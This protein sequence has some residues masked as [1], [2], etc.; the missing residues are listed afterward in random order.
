MNYNEITVK[1]YYDIAEIILADIP[2]LQMNTEVISLLYGVN[3]EDVPIAELQKYLEGISFLKESYQPKRPKAS[4][5][6]LGRKFNP[7][8]NLGSF[9][10]AQFVDYQAFVKTSDNKHILNCILVEAG[11]QYGEDNSEF[12][13]TNLKYSDYM[14]LISFYSSFLEAYIKNMSHSLGK[15]LKKMKLPKDQVK[16]LEEILLQIGEDE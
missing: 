8:L 7:V 5:S 14:D 16:Q 9:T 1:Q 3:A 6:L 4:Y 11:K 13:W 12:L 15:K 10:T 2:E